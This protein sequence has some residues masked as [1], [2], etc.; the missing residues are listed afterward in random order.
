MHRLPGTADEHVG[1]RTFA[2]TF[3]PPVLVMLGVALTYVFAD[4]PVE[5]LTSEPTTQAD[6]PPY[7]GSVSTLGVM[8]WSAAIGIFL[9]GAALLYEKLERREA[10]FLAYGAIFTAYLA[11][12]DAFALHESVFPSIGIPEEAVYA[13]ILL[14]TIIYA[15]LFRPQIKAAAWLFLALAVMALA[16]SVAV[17]VIWQLLDPSSGYALQMLVEDGLKLVGIAAW[18]AYAAMSTR[19]LVRHH[20]ARDSSAVSTAPRRQDLTTAS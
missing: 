6:V 10:A 9:L 15:W 14:L 5:V 1:I 18:V 13:G 11:V 3:I 7:T 17:D 2:Y 12:D 20:F 8:G 4:I 16:G 19:G